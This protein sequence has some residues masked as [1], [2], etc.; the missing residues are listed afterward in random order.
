MMSIWLSSK[1]FL[2]WVSPLSKLQQKSEHTHQKKKNHLRVEGSHQT[3][4]FFGF[5]LKEKQQRNGNRM[6]T[7][8]IE[9]LGGH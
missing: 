5:F 4:N 6:E 7:K 2:F 3:T 9:T 1:D 8:F